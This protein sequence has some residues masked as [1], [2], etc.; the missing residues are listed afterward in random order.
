MRQPRHHLELDLQAK[1]ATESMVV[2][3]KLMLE[4]KISVERNVLR[5]FGIEAAIDFEPCP[6]FIC[7]ER[8][9]TVL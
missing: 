9:K 1:F 4:L 2:A 3:V 7:L 5:E 8:N 6:A